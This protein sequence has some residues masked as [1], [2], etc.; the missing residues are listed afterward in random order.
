MNGLLLS[1]G[2]ALLLLLLGVWLAWPVA[3]HAYQR[4]KLKK[5]IEALGDQHLRDVML[6]DGMGGQ[7]YFEWLLLTD[8]GI[9]LLITRQ[10]AGNIFAG[11]RLENWAQVQGNRTRYFTNPLHDLDPLIATLNYHLPGIVIRT[12]ILFSG[13]CHFPKGRPATVLTR[14][15]LFNQGGPRTIPLALHRAWS[16]LEKKAQRPDPYTRAHLLPHREDLPFWRLWLT[17]GLLLLAVA[18]VNWNP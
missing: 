9:C 8:E 15:E 13:D 5:G 16:Q 2:P 4:Y 11:E 3:C 14:E 10:Y 18:W 12:V 1:W 17:G 6:D 7:S